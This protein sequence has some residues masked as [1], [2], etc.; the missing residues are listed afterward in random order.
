MKTTY[1]VTFDDDSQFWAAAETPAELFI[2]IMRYVDGANS[3]FEK[4]VVAL[5]SMA[6]CASLYNTF[7]TYER[8]KRI[9]EVELVYGM[10]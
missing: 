3:V 7:K 2:A 8:V 1:M 6:D 10:Q 5:D 4:A 9:H